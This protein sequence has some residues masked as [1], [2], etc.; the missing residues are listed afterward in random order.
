MTNFLRKNACIGIVHFMAYPQVMKGEGPVAETLFSILEDDYFDAVEVTWVSD[1]GEARRVAAMLRT[2]HV[3]VGYGAQPILLGKGLNLNARETGERAKA[4]EAVRTCFDQAAEFGAETVA[5][6]SGPWL[7][8]TEYPTEE[9]LV[10]SLTILG[11]EAAQKGLGL[12]LEVFDDK[13]DKKCFVGKWP[14]ALRVGQRVRAECQGFGLMHDLSHLPILD[15]K[16]ETSLPPLRELLVHM[17]MGNAVVSDPSHDAYG[18][19]HPRFGVEG[20]ANDVLELAN[21]LRVLRDIEYF[22]GEKRRGLA[23]EVK[24]MA[25]EDSRLVIANAKRTLNAAANL[26]GLS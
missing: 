21:F 14:V 20:G 13:I 24:P 3:R 1:P 6:L 18:D 25:G 26:A 19:Q 11:H 10:E 9:A 2:S 22:G 16:P 17:H 8:G 4:V 23:F 5:V 15:E 7:A 12:T